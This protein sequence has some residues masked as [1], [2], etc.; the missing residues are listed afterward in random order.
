MK[1]SLFFL[2]FLSINFAWGWQLPELTEKEQKEL[3]RSGVVHRLWAQADSPWPASTILAYLDVPADVAIGIFSDYSAHKNF[4]PKIIESNIKQSFEGGKRAH[5]SFIID[6]PLLADSHFTMED[7]LVDLGQ[8]AYEVKWTQ[9][10]S[11]S[12]LKSDGHARFYP[13]GASKSLF[14]YHSSVTPKG[15][16]AILLEKLAVKECR[17]AYDAIITHL[18]ATFAKGGDYTKQRQAVIHELFAPAPKKNSSK[19]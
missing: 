19:H 12:T 10:E 17:R 6:I 11:D 16:V 5:V 13:V 2:F 4:V 8:G 3:A 9:V 18:K 15:R 1:N 14:E 7:T